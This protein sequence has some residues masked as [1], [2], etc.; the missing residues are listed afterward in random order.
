MGLRIRRSIKIAPGVRLNVS[1]SGFST[2]ERL[3]PVTINSRRGATVHLAK[4]VSYTAG[5]SGRRHKG[6]GGNRAVA[7]IKR[8]RG[9]GCWL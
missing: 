3:G 8:M 7:P 5:G 9:C 1:K 2:S 4:G 6:V